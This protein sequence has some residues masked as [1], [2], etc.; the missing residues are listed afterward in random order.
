M[1]CDHGFFPIT[2][3]TQKMDIVRH[4]WIFQ[5]WMMQQLLVSE[6]DELSIGN[7]CSHNI[8]QIQYT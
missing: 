8:C 4:G 1:L 5:L 6:K 2:V 7:S 3:T